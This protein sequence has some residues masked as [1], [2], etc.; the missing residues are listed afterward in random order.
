MTELYLIR[1]GQASFGSEDYDR[2]SELGVLQ[3][4]RLGEHLRRQE[5][6]FEA[7]YSGPH[8]RQR[9]TAAQALGEDGIEVREQFAEYHGGALF[10]HY[11]PGVL[12]ANPQLAAEQGQLRQD[13]RSFQL[14]L[15]QVLEAW[16]GDQAPPPGLERWQDFRG[17]VVGGLEELVSVHRGHQR[18]AVFSSGG[19]IGCAVAHALRLSL[20][21]GLKLSYALYNTSV[22]RLRYGRLGW[23]LTLFNG[24]SHLEQ[25]GGAD[26]VTYR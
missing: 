6:S 22:C 5:V 10:E 9:H 19:A 4:R 2:L 14:T 21:E 20:P 16:C 1:H 23:L 8:R 7:V 15:E 26:L 17:R 13:R 24:L 11:L 18:V 12:A 3:S 25:G